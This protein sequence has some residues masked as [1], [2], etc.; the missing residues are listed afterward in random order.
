MEDVGKRVSKHDNLL[1]VVT[2]PPDN[3]SLPRR[4]RGTA[5]YRGSRDDHVTSMP[6]DLYYYMK[7]LPAYQRFERGLAEISLVRAGMVIA[8]RCK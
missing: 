7:Q 8:A 3:K 1:T 2:Y 4:S 5:R 6:S